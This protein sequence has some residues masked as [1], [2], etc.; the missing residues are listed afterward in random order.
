M[1]TPLYDISRLVE[2]ELR[3]H[4]GERAQRGVRDYASA[5]FDLSIVESLQ[6][7]E[8]VSHCTDALNY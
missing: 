1:E 6:E 3:Q 4:Q 7:H 5:K 8:A 2:D